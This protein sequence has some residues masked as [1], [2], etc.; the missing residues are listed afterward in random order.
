VYWVL[1]LSQ[2]FLGLG[3]LCWLQGGVKFRP[4]WFAE[5]RLGARL[6]SWLNLVVFLL[7]NVFVLPAAVVLYLG[8]CLSLAVDHFSDGFLALH[9][10]GL[11]VEVRKYVRDDG[12]RV[13]LIPMAHIGQAEFYRRMAESFPSNSII[14]MEG[15]TDG[16]GR[17]TNE[18][19][20][21]RMAKSVGLAE[22]EQ[23]FQPTRGEMVH[24]DV[25]VE[26]FSPAT[27]DFLNLA[28]LMHSKG[29]RP[30]V[31]MQMLQ[32]SSAPHFEQQLLEDVLRKR[33]RRVLQEIE[34]Q[35]PKSDNIVVPWGVAHM[36]GIAEGIRKSGFGL[37]ES[38]E[39]QVIRFR[40]PRR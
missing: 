18:L 13:H 24:A 14:L 39:Y 34:A 15:V 36:P 8:L 7:A 31:I 2:V 26:Q 35:L 28:A 4:P 33:N 37:E 19:S 1:S 32:Y 17:L 16:Q 25:D 11:T 29:L 38:R 9:P 30:E 23:E 10:D 3:V 12:K 20:Y 6:F 27:I 40:G 21:Q 5:A 22:Q